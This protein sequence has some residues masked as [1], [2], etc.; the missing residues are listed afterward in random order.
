MS[1]VQSSADVANAVDSTCNCHGSVVGSSLNC[2][3]AFINYVAR[4]R[5]FPVLVRWK[6]DRRGG[7]CGKDFEWCGLQM[8][9]AVDWLIRN[10]GIFASLLL[11]R[12]KGDRR[13][14]SCGKDFE[15]C[16]LQMQDA[17]DWLI[18]NFGIFASLLLI[19]QP[20]GTSIY[21]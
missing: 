17:V 13:G 8:Q 10:F 7:S 5:S 12:W 20:A 18:R 1:E 21:E 19:P 6:G 9:D 2:W 4:N 11:V 3:W 16:G 14:G 15:W